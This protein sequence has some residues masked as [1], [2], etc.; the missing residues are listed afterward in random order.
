MYCLVPLGAPPHDNA[1]LTPPPSAKHVF[2]KGNI[3][4]SDVTMSGLFIQNPSGTAG[5]VA[6]SFFKRKLN[7]DCESDVDDDAA[8]DKKTNMAATNT[9]D[10]STMKTIL[11]RGEDEERSTICR[12]VSKQARQY[13]I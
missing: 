10:A 6:T 7:D 9:A 3:S 1:G 12:S 11:V 2:A 8:D 4:L 13:I 5:A